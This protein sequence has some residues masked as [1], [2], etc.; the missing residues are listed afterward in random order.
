MQLLI[1]TI[2]AFTTYLFIAVLF[3][4][5][6]YN[7][8]KIRV[9]R[10]QKMELEAAHTGVHRHD[11]PET[12][13]IVDG[14]RYSSMDSKCIAQGSTMLG[15]AWLMRSN[16]NN[17]YMISQSILGQGIFPQTQEQA[18]AFHTSC[19]VREVPFDKAFPGVKIQDA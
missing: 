10:R 14:K 11:V 15:W 12:T 18:I 9:A 19:S 8:H 2:F 16:N 7:F 3:F 1:T 6:G 17:Y 5:T 13:Q 4:I